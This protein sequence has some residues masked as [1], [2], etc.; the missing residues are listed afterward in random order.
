MRL[1]RPEDIALA[2][3]VFVDAGVLLE[4]GAGGLEIGDDSMVMSGCLLQVYNHRALPH[5]GIRVGRRAY[6]G[7]RTLMRGQGGVT[8]GDNVLFGPGV[9]VLAVEP[10]TSP[11]ARVRSAIRASPRSASASRTTAGSAPARSSST[12]SPSAAAPASAPA[13]SSR[14][15]SP[16]RTLAVG[17]PAR[18]V[19]DLDAAAPS[20]A[21]V[22]L[23]GL[24]E[25][26]RR[27]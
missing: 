17:V 14:G 5:A 19:R 6:I 16:R 7:E 15:R 27:R 3:G 20:R 26:G 8:I 1:R 9:Q 13:P 23:G 18:V 4:G 12:A 11:T 25:M 10:R 22:H 24:A 2:N 21:E